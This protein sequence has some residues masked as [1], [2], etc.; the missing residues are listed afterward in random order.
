[1]ENINIIRTYKP[2]NTGTTL[3]SDILQFTTK[4]VDRDDNTV[5]VN[6][7]E[8]G[9]RAIIVGVDNKVVSDIEI[10]VLLEGY[11]LKE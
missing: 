5:E 7:L 9:N 11:K 8:S 6:V 10:G 4:Y 3:S 1:M 2:L